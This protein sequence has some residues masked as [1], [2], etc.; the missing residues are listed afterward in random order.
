MTSARDT[1][2]RGRKRVALVPATRVVSRATRPRYRSSEIASNDPR[3]RIAGTL[4]SRSIR[5]SAALSRRLSPLVCP[6]GFTRRDNAAACR[7]PN[8]RFP[9]LSRRWTTMMTI[10]SITVERSTVARVRPARARARAYPLSFSF[11]RSPS[12]RSFGV[13]LRYLIL[14]RSPD[15]DRRPR[16]TL[17][18]RPCPDISRAG[19]QTR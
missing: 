18:R 8:N 11:S 10:S 1:P 15:E 9:R 7:S 14:V 17:R 19:G 4:Y 16:A 5:G 13:L 12:P 6:S 3:Y 2:C